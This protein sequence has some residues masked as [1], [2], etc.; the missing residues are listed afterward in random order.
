MNNSPKPTSSPH[1]DT[2]HHKD[3][4]EA[5]EDQAEWPDPEGPGLG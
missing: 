3:G 5:A 1:K 4:A 2:G